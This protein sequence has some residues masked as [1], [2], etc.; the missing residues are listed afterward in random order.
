MVKRFK[1][2]TRSLSNLKAQAMCVLFGKRRAGKTTMAKYLANKMSR[3]VGRFVAFCGTKKTQRVWGAMIPSVYVHGMDIEK[4]RALIKYQESKIEPLLDAWEE[5]GND[6]DDFVV[7]AHLRLCI[8]FDDVGFDHAFCNNKTMK[9]IT[10][11]GRHYGLDVMFLF[12]DFK[13]MM[14]A[15]RK[16]ADYIFAMAN[17][18]ATFSDNVY[19]TYVG[20]SV[21]S[22]SEWSNLYKACTNRLGKVC[23]I[24]NTVS[25]TGA[26]QKI[27]IVKVP[28]RKYARVGCKEYLDYADKHSRQKNLSAE[29][30]RA[31]ESRVKRY[32]NIEVAEGMTEYTDTHHDEFDAIKP[33]PMRSTPDTHDAHDVIKPRSRLRHNV[34]TGLRRRDRTRFD[35][36][37]L[38]ASDDVETDSVL[39]FR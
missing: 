5:E 9:D 4:V 19:S 24:D 3:T 33:R 29:Q 7:P 27:S 20:K 6:P 1:I 39:S 15:L 16:Q 11:N 28:L 25:S 14:P 12:Q 36:G 17:D 8:I 32:G 13:Q 18:D 34:S 21:D 2:A 23:M 35:S 22:K 30:R 38:F 31:A 10:A 37:R 26:E